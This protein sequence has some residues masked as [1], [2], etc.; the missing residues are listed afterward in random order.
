MKR[1]SI[2]LLL[3]FALVVGGEFAYWR[4]AVG[5]LQAGFND[6]AAA[7]TAAGWTIKA[8]TPVAGGWPLSATLTMPDVTVSATGAALP[9]PAVWHAAS[10]SLSVD[11]FSPTHLRIQAYG[12]Q[13]IRLGDGPSIPYTAD[14][15][16]VSVPLTPPGPT[17][18]VEVSAAGIQGA[19]GPDLDASGF[20]V[21]LLSAHLRATPE[22]KA[23]QPAF[24]VV[25]AAES[26]TVRPEAVA[27]LGA[28]FGNRMPSVVVEAALTGPVPP[29]GDPGPRARQWRDAGGKLD[30]V[31]FVLGWGTLGLHGQG[32]LTLDPNLQPSGSGQVQ[33]VDYGAAIE[34]LTR[35]H[36]IGAGAAL[37]ARAVLSVV[38]QASDN[39]DVRSADVPLTLADG[40]LMLD[41]FPLAK[42]PSLSLP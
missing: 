39:S 33:V 30:I 32:T 31:R 8:G 16:T 12:D 35:A 13:T 27:P 26:V 5:R 17:V 36:V 41:R 42:V 4:T 40:I 24:G 20:G 34:S 23:G 37:S 22:A 6:L 7:R 28:A 9:V 1:L 29:P 38:S 18:Q 2:A 21:A 3:I 19:T 11:L 14:R 10:A 15:L 25:M